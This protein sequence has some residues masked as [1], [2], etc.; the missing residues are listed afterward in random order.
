VWAQ[1]ALYLLT[2]GWWGGALGTPGPAFLGLDEHSRNTRAYR[3]GP[4][5][6]GGEPWSRCVL[7]LSWILDALRGEELRAIRSCCR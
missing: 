1:I 5:A 2:C 4:N 7:V 6:P 3:V